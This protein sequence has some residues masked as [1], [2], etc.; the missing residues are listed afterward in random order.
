MASRRVVHTAL[1]CP[2]GRRRVGL[3]EPPLALF[4]AAV[5]VFQALTH[6]ELPNAVRVMDELLE[7]AVDVAT[8]S[9]SQAGALLRA[10]RPQ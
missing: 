9:T 1:R 5:L 7:G 10:M 2:C 3:I 8:S 4:I 6:T